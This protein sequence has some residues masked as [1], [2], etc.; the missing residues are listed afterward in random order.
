[1]RKRDEGSKQRLRRHLLGWAQNLVIVLLLVSTVALV[2]ES[3]MLD[4]SAVKGAGS[5]QNSVDRHAAYTAA[6]KPMCVVLTPES[7]MH[8]A[9]M[10]EADALELAYERYSSTLAEAL[11][12]SGEPEQITQEQWEA[13]LSG[14]G[15]YFDYYGDY[16]LSILAIWLGTEMS[17]EA[18]GHTARR[19]CLAIEGEDVYLCYI[20]ERGEGGYYRCATAVSAADLL[21]R[22]SESMPN[23]AEYNFELDEPL[24]Y[25][26]R[27]MVILSS[28]VNIESASASNSLPSADTDDIMSKLG[29]NS[30]LA[31]SYPE[32]DGGTVKIEG[33][34]TLKLGVD[35][36]LRYSRRVLESEEGTRLSPTDAI[37][38]ARQLVEATAGS[39]AGDAE[40]WLSYIYFDR[41]TQEY[42]L[43]FDYVLSGLPVS[44]QGRDNAVE[45]VIYG[46]S[47]VSAAMLFRSYELLSSPVTP[48]P[49]PSLIAATLVQSQGGGEPRLCYVDRPEG[50]SAEWRIV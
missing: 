28:D 47:I 5:E 41:E 20:R 25:I 33:D 38:L 27:Y 42:T 9:I 45:I 36:E 23:G 2:A 44:I 17:G 4:L 37:E 39:A 40:L 21:G 31:L 29:M 46:D 19:F 30:Y 18:S 14:P 24:S 7:G 11:G 22:V 26:D 49:Y 3:G 34:A 8:S 12:S 15:V 10:Y 50:M 48:S 6:A 16:Q 43:N 35:G 13:A 32:S 1:M